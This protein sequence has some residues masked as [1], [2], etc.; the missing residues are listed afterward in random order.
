MAAGIAYDTP[1]LRYLWLS[2]PYFHDGS[3]ATLRDVFAQPGTHQLSI[4]QSD[5]D[6]LIAYLMTW[7]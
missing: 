2:A 7:P 1:S 6:A 4:E 5:M 3:A